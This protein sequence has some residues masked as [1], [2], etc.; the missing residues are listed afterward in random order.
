[1]KERKNDQKQVIYYLD[2]S[3]PLLEAFSLMA[4]I[5]DCTVVI[6]SD[7]FEFLKEVKTVSHHD[8]ILLVDFNLK[9]PSIN[10]IKVIENL[11]SDDYGGFAS[12]YLFTGQELDQE[13]IKGLCSFNP[14]RVSYLK[15]NNESFIYLLEKR[16]GLCS[17][18]ED[19]GIKK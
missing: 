13:I 9:L 18:D 11:K 2:D 16:L 6:Y 17:V 7:P 8:H 15:K 19:V 5:Y 1:L 3:I 4:E 10:G 14:S 12:I